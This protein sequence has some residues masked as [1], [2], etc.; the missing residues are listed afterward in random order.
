MLCLAVFLSTAAV[1][2]SGQ[3]KPAA[4]RIVVIEGEDG[5][6]I[7]QQKSAVQPVVEVRDQNNLPVAGASVVFLIG[8][9][10]NAAT[11]A[12][13]VSQVTVVTDA[14]GRAAATGLQPV[15]NGAYSIQVTATSQGQTATASISQTNFA[16]VAEA[17]QAG[18]TP[19]SQSGSSASSGG[20]GAGAGAGA[21]AGGGLSGV[22][23]G[24]IVAGAAAGGL[25]A[26]KAAGGDDS[27][28]TTPQTPTTTTP[29]PTTPTPPPTTPTPPPTTPTPPPTTPTPPPTAPVCTT[30]FAALTAA[31]DR[32]VGIVNTCVTATNDSCI[33]QFGKAFNDYYNVLN[34]LCSCLGTKLKAEQRAQIRESY[35]VYLEFAGDIGLPAPPPI[36]ACFQ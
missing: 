14:A 12:N 31:V 8:G 24:G 30:Q 15:G 6:N 20:S 3:T 33:A 13:G 25:V 28:T 1:P 27:T 32:L 26:A 16:S 36:P 21:G 18:K 29:P 19:T 7:I 2:S 11:F 5:V 10:S 23:I 4:L 22:A 35:Q 17:A 34:S 9:G